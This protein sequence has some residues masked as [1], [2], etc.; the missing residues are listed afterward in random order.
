MAGHSKWANIQHRKGR[1]D[2]KRAKVF[3]KLS[4]EI[5]VAGKDGADPAAN[6]R[7]S[8]AIQ[9][10]KDANM[11]NTNIQRLLDKLQGQADGVGY[12]E[13]CYE[14][15]GPQGIAFLLEAVTD[16]RNRTAPEIRTILGKSGGNLGQD[17][18]VSWM[19]TK[20]GEV[21]VSDQELDEESIFLQAAEA[22][23][24]DFMLLEDQWMAICEPELL[25]ACK[26]NLE[27]Q[28]LTVT[29]AKFG[30]VADS[31]V[32]VEDLELAQQVITLFERLE[33]HDDIQAVYSNF[34]LS[35]SVAQQLEE[36]AV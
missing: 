32:V 30:M 33:D 2:Q 9:R 35:N 7:L 3:T 22:G 12:E 34:E 16:N 13:I 36:E 1:Q 21:F 10:A 15:Y 18:C 29:E 17:G 19:F 28:G 23:A 6:F 14:G 11:P 25:H 31:F 24:S 4:K 8:V 27:E 20:R 5:L 26:V